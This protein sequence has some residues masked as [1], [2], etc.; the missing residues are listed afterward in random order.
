M[1]VS[2][3]SLTNGVDGSR[4]RV[5][6]PIP[7]TSTIIV[8]YLARTCFGLFPREVG[9]EQPSSLS[10]FIIRPYTQSLVYVVSHRVDARI[11]A[12]ECTGADK[13]P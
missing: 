10:S 13:L 2:K 12:C 9:N 3:H 1:P 6:K 7:C 5:Q 8:R 4:T 11:P